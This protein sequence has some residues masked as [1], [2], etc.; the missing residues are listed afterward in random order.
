MIYLTPGPTQLYPGLEE[1]ML[2]CLRRDVGSISHRSGAFQKIYAETENNLRTLLGLPED[3]HV[4]FLPSATEAWERIPRSLVLRRSDHLVCGA[5]SKKFYEFAVGLG[6]EVG[7]WEAPTG[8]G[9]T[10]LMVQAPKE[11]ELLAITH[12][13]TSTGVQCPALDITKLSEAY[14]HALVAVDAVSSLPYPAFDYHAIDTAFFS[15]QKC[16]GLPAGLGVWLV[17]PRAVE[18]AEKLQSVGHNPGPHHNLLSLV[19]MAKKHQNP[20]TP[21]V[22]GIDLLGYVTAA[23]LRKGIDTI[24][25]ETE[26][27][28]KLLY[29]FASKSD[30]FTPSVAVEAHRS[31]TV[32]VLDT[33]LSSAKVNE[34]LEPFGMKVGSGYGDK[35]DSQLRIANFP[36]HS[37]ETIEALCQQLQIQQAYA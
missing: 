36:M 20:N 22:L 34:L 19:K 35:K 24:R 4:L 32:V 10:P 2:D 27:K 26:L 31:R 3:W 1:A 29:D 25:T 37:V 13:E 5:F 17:G 7:K 12:N 6:L 15:V 33:K 30:V 21:N 23:M 28:A 18:K 8:Q 16:F 14:P 9:V 11:T